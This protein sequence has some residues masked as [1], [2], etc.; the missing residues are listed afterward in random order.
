MTAVKKNLLW[1]VYALFIVIAF[2]YRTDE[3]LF[4]SSGPYALGKPLVWAIYIGFLLYTIRCSR[5]ESFFKSLKKLSPIL[6]ARQIGIDLYI[7]LVLFSSLIY[8]NEGSF[9]ILVL[10]LIPILIFANLATLPYL[11]LN[12]DAIMGYFI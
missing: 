1:V 6:W 4:L 5:K 7:G 3:D 9:L 2:L 10:W 12:Y 11:I 8:I